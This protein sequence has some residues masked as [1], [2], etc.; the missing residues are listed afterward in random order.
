MSI[1]WAGVWKDGVEVVDGICHSQAEHRGEAEGDQ[2]DVDRTMRR[3]RG[4]RGRNG[5]GDV[6]DSRSIECVGGALL[7]PLGEIQQIVLLVG[8]RLAL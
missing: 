3:Q 8:L 7:L 1:T 4:D 2:K 5:D 6:R